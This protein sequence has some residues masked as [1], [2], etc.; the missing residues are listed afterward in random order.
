[1]RFK[2]TPKLNCEVITKRTFRASD[3]SHGHMTFVITDVRRAVDIRRGRNIEFYEVNQSDVMYSLK[4][5]RKHFLP[6]LPEEEK[7]E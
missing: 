1:L 4:Y 2:W 3:G 6:L 7:D 5:M